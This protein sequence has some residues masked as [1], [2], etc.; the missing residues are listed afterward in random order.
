MD[1]QKYRIIQLIN[2][3]KKIITAIR[4]L[5]ETAE[6]NKIYY[7]LKL[8]KYNL[9]VRSDLFVFLEDLPN[10]PESYLK[11]LESVGIIRRNPIFPNIIEIVD[12]DSV[13]QAINLLSNNNS[14]EII[15][16]SVRTIEE[17]ERE[18]KKDYISELLPY[19]AP[20]VEE[21]QGLDKV[22]VAMLLQLFSCRDLPNLRNRIHILLVGDPG[23]GKTV[24]L[25][26]ITDVGDGLYR[27]L[28]MTAA[29]L[30]GSLRSIA[31][32]DNKPLLQ[33]ANGKILALDEIDKLNR[34]DLDPL[35][36]A[37][38]EGIVTL[39]GAELDV[40]YEAKVRIIAAA[41]RRTKMRPELIDRFDYYRQ[42]RKLTKREISS[43]IER[44]VDFVSTEEKSNYL[45]VGKMIIKRL[46]RK[47]SK[48]IP[49]I[50]DPDGVKNEIDNILAKTGMGLDSVRQ[51]Q[52]WLRFAYAYAK[53]NKVNVNGAV[54]KKVY[55]LLSG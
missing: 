5:V 17:I 9:P 29:G 35:L 4:I 19:V 6:A 12:V 47:R 7:Y 38:E 22:K 20:H 42:L 39:S 33:R 27:S 10:F 15:Q 40:T 52:K 3:D 25:K 23:T 24:L 45:E 8:N 34:E 44:I 14:K 26:W 28:R 54:V 55:E 18:P 51:T 37:M 49:K 31:Y 21:V 2:Q 43:V 13:I 41:N 46:I 32:M 1:A 50:T 16:E 30:G 53:I 11:K 36:S 48:F